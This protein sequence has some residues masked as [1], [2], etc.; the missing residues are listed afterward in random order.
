MSELLTL[1]SDYIDRMSNPTFGAAVNEDYGTRFAALLQSKEFQRSFDES[2]RELSDRG[3]LSAYG[4]LWLLG[5]VKARQISLREDLLAELFLEWSSVFVRSEIIDVATQ[6]ADQLE[7]SLTRPSLAEFP[8]GFLRKVL[9]IVTREPE[10]PFMSDIE[11]REQKAAP[12]RSTA[13]AESALV[14]LIQVGR[15]ITLS[16]AA[17]L[18][19]H[20]WKG[21]DQVVQFFWTLFDSLDQETQSVWLQRIDPPSRRP[22]L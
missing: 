15:P 20:R 9:T 5:Y 18:L 3:T 12:E 11:L 22:G 14:A 19:H 7:T 10:Q 13:L 4:W 2:I 8:N 1:A 17:T 6:V 16:A 21:R